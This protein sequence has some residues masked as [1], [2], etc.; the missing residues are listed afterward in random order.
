VIDNRQ[1]FYTINL[2]M[3]NNMYMTTSCKL[4]HHYYSLPF[5]LDTAY[6]DMKLCGEHL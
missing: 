2:K 4:G 3:I 6:L 1:I 5:P